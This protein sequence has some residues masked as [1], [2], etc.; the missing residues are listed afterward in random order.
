MP[1]LFPL[2]P[3]RHTIAFV[4]ELSLESESRFVEGDGAGYIRD[5]YDRVSKFHGLDLP[6]ASGRSLE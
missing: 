4:N 6:S 1:T 5:V 2:Y 3:A